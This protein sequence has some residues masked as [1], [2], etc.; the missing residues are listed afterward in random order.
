MAFE[1]ISKRR[2]AVS[3]T[4]FMISAIFLALSFVR[5]AQNAE[6]TEK[7][8]FDTTQDFVR[9][10]D[11]GQGDSILIYSNGYSALIDTGL[12][13]EANEVC[14]ELEKCGI[15]RLDVLLI[16]HLDSDHSGGIPTICSS[17]EIENLILP[18][19]SIES[20]GLTKAEFA[21]NEISQR[22]GGIYT[23]IEGM[24][25][26]IGEFE[27]TILAA[28]A[29]LLTENNRSVIA[30]AEMN[31][32]KFLFTGDAE[33][34]AEKELLSAGLNLKC[35]VLKV[36]HHGSSTS[37]TDSFL[38]AVR[39]RYAAVSVGADNIYGHPHD[40]VL[41]RFENLN[42]EIFRTDLNGNI[43][44]YVVDEKIKVETE[45]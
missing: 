39:P 20:E 15:K 10:I 6:Q 40:E 17:Y 28:N 37:S 29:H 43:T 35:D 9:V 8:A 23:A 22:G 34:K 2:L 30:I 44:F 26:E 14:F 1:K 36:G 11:V 19:L 13:D 3:V 32:K 41:S 33:A 38:K 5:S 21:I 18:E 42:T 16:T 7:S 27:I 45:R 25:F 12:S 24:N 31:D 4:V